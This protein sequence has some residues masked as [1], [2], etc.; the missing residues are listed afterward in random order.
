MPRHLVIQLAR[1]GDLLQ[2]KRLLAS[3]CAAGETHLLV[4]RSLASLAALVYPDVHVHSLCA[5]GHA[6]PTEV[7][8]ACRSAVQQL[9]ELDFDLVCNLNYSGL[10]LAL[11]ACF[12]PERVRGHK[13][14]SGQPLRSPW[15][16]M[17]FRL[18]RRRQ[19]TPLN[20]V[21]YWAL[22]L[23]APIPGQ[24]VN[25]PAEPKGGGLGVVLAGREARRSLPMDVLVP[26]ARAVM[27][28]AGLSSATLLGSS[29]EQPAAR[30]FLR[31]APSALANAVTDLS[32]KTDW[33]ALVDV[34]QGLDLVL[35]PDTGVMHLAAHCG[36][37][38]LATFL[39]SAWA[40][41]TGPYGEGHLVLQSTEDC[42]PC[43]ESRPCSNDLRCLEP[44]RGRELLR[45][46]GKALARGW[47][48]AP[49]PPLGVAVLRAAFD[50]LGQTCVPVCG[51]DPN[52]RLRLSRR[53]LLQEL[54]TAAGPLPLAGEAADALIQERDWMLERGA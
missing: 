50:S 42:A 49:E 48:H 36:T 51:H 17:G 34:V 39:S 37:P 3:L 1:F 54:R 22:L 15:T 5:H 40:W 53:Q 45:L 46:L 52:A 13:L 16:D 27:Q 21:D 23:D 47:E 26:L 12:A 19:A 4:D 31:R 44:F 10:N 29:A 32:G 2:T 35:T 24:E 9:Q 43:V 33:P 41:E 25:P 20:L 28:G 18:S 6:D 38:V 14:V 11:A 7:F 30:D 8:S